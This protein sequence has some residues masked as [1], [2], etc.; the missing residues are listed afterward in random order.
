[1]KVSV[2]IGEDKVDLFDDEKISITQKLNDIEKLS[3]VFTDF[4]NSF[5]VPATQANNR[6]LK[7][8]YDV[9]INNGAIGFIPKSHLL[10]DYKRAFPFPAYY[11]PIVS[12]EVELMNYM[13]IIDM[14]AGEMVFFMNNTVHGSFANYTDKIRYAININFVKKY[15]L[16]L[17]LYL[18]ISIRS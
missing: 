17:L 10:Y 15:S 6:I 11:T 1:M 9:D 2:Y 7:H 12:N 5:T 8:Y 3:N 4:T 13:E 18:H 14:K 16:L